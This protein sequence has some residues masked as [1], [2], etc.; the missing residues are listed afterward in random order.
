ML[1]DNEITLNLKSNL[2]TY[3]LWDFHNKNFKKELNS[4]FFTAAITKIY[5]K[6]EIYDKLQNL[7]NLK[8]DLEEYRG[9]L[10]SQKKNYIIFKSKK[11]L[12]FNNLKL[13]FSNLLKGYFV[14]LT[15]L[16]FIG[17][18]TVVNFLCLKFFQLKEFPLTI[19]YKKEEKYIL[20]INI[21][22]KI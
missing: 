14:N 1:I 7:E 16:Y 15:N 5:N 10:R 11:D 21:L 2:Q 12:V 18:I 20:L 13:F 22:E 8:K 6:K 9:H 17:F 19:M 3:D 4:A